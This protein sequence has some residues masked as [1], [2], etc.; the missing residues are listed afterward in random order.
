L[1]LTG[2]NP[3]IQAK[4]RYSNATLPT[5]DST[6][7]GLGLNPGLCDENLAANRPSYDMTHNVDMN[8]EMMTL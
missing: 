5:T 2:E 4:W 7:T 8:K 6:W 1:I 3:I